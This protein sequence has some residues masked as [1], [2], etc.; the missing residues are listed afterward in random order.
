MVIV[1]TP[2]LLE[3]MVCAQT[4][5]QGEGSHNMMQNVRE[6]IDGQMY[7]TQRGVCT[8]LWPGV[9]VTTKQ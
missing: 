6:L 5:L 9:E 2:L 7:V 1:G 8:T 3:K 4:P